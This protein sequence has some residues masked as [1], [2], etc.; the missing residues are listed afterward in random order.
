MK[1]VKFELRARCK[2]FDANGAVVDEEIVNPSRET[3]TAI[4][5]KNA[6]AIWLCLGREWSVD[7]IKIPDDVTYLRLDFPP[8]GS[9]DRY[10]HQYDGFCAD[11]LRIPSSVRHLVLNNPIS[12]D[13]AYYSDHLRTLQVSGCVPTDL[14]SGLQSLMLINPGNLTSLLLPSTLRTLEMAST[15]CSLDLDGLYVPHTITRLNL[16]HPGRL[17]HFVWPLS[18]TKLRLVVRESLPFMEFPQTLKE[19]EVV[20]T[21]N[22]DCDWGW[23]QYVQELTVSHPGSPQLICTTPSNLRNLTLTLER[24]TDLIVADSSSMIEL[25]SAFLCGGRVP[26]RIRHITLSGVTSLRIRPSSI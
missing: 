24:K 16:M 8:M 15:G 1:R 11:G 4:A 14:P 2:T 20:Y 13:G 21:S 5:G 9:S 19:V 25:V 10:A 3:L 7:D 17:D 23:M 6:S 18:L 22:C 26:P 12:L